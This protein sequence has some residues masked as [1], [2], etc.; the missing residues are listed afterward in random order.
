MK[1]TGLFV[2]CLLIAG[3]LFFLGGCFYAYHPDEYY[4]YG[5]T[6]LYMPLPPLSLWY[7]DRH[8]SFGTDISP[9]G[10]YY[11]Y[12]GYPYYPYPRHRFRY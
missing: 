2:K 6:Q 8:F 10:Y 7:S 1:Q 11:P 4:P 12:R 9:Y 3:G 5:Q